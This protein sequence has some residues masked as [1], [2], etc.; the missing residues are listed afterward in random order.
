MAR[1]ILPADDLFQVFIE[2]INYLFE[3][4]FL[5]LFFFDHV[6]GCLAHELH[7]AQLLGG[8]FE[9]FLHIFELFVYPLLFRVDINQP[10]QR[11]I[12]FRPADDR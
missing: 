4:F 12:D 2:F 5:V 1:K 8:L 9:L 11:D 10:G 3:I 7:I 6:P